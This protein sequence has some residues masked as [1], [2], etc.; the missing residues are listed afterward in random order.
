MLD[1]L[2]MDL[3]YGL[4]ALTRR[5]V[6]TANVVLTLGLGIGTLLLSGLGGRSGR[7]AA[8]RL[9]TDFDRAACPDGSAAQRQDCPR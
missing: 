7:R 2:W 9:T 1:A 6:F 4:K 5:P 3:R 8:S